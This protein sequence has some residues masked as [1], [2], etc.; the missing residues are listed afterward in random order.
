MKQTLSTP[1]SPLINF[2]LVAFRG[3]FLLVTIALII[4]I[5]IGIIQLFS[6]EPTNYANLPVTFT[7][8]ETGN[9]VNNGDTTSTRFTLYNGKGFINST[10]F[11]LTSVIL[12]KLVTVAVSLCILFIIKLVCQILEAAKTGRFL[13]AR[14][15]VRMR[16]MALLFILAFMVEKIYFLISA[17]YLADKLV[18]PGVHFTKISFYTFA[19]WEYILFFLFLLVIAEAFRIGA[20]LKNENDLTI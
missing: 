19:Q 16:N 13:V 2:L 5:A 11:S 20:Q 10:S 17:S 9:F 15:A 8:S 12:S 18:F 14:N 4:Y 1:T 3:L 6:K 7:F